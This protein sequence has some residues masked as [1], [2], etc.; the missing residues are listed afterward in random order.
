MGSEITKQVK[1]Q[2]YKVNILSEPEG[3]TT[4]PSLTKEYKQYVNMI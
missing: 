2:L 1:N 3:C 4:I